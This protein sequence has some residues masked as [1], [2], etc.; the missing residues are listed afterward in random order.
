MTRVK[1]LATA[2]VVVAALA[3]WYNYV[4][5]S[6]PGNREEHQRLSLVVTFSPDRVGDTGV[7]IDVF[8]GSQ[9]VGGVPSDPDGTQ[10]Q[11]ASPWTDTVDAPR[12]KVVSLRATRAGLRHLGCQ[13]HEGPISGALVDDDEIDSGGTVYCQHVVTG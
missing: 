12:G 4:P 2:V 8:V 7:R 11:R 1:I 3:F 6:T 10:G 9:R 13:I 5:G